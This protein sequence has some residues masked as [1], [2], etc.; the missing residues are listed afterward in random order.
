MAVKLFVIP[1]RDL[2]AG[3]EALNGFL[4]SHR[5]VSVRSEAIA[6]G[7]NSFWM[8]TV[9][10]VTGANRSAAGAAAAKAAFHGK[11][12]Y[13]TILS[14]EEFGVFSRLRELRKELSLR[15]AIPVYAI[16][17]NEQL[18]QMVQQRC[19]SIGEL[20]RIEGVGEQ[21]LEKY[22]AQLLPVL[23][24]LK[25]VETSDAAGKAAV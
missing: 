13:R 7:A 12:D 8:M 5:V 22:S 19:R 10:Y 23:M 21:K 4:S 1:A 6:D 9:E 2:A 18:A 17:T 14:E 20:G 25:P 11:V 3:E 15:E 16:F 24:A